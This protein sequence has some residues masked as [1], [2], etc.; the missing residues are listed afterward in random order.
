MIQ[1]VSQKNPRDIANTLLDRLW[2]IGKRLIFTK[3]NTSLS[4]MPEPREQI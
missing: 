1:D 3:C 4:E 2:K